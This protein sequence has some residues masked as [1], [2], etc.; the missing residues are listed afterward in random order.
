MR[1]SQKDK[2]RER[3]RERERKREREEMQNVRNVSSPENT[4][5]WQ[6]LSSAEPVFCCFT[7]KVALSGSQ[8]VQGTKTH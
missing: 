2:E 3:E 5:P 1:T 8:K 4:W 7:V 6:L